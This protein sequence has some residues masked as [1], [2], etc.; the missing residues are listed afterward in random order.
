MTVSTSSIDLR[1]LVREIP[2]FPKPGILFRDLTP[3]MRDIDVWQEVIRRLSD[4]CEPLQPDLIVGIESRGFIVGMALSMAMGLGFVP[5][6]KPGKLPGLLHRVDYELEYGSDRLEIQRDAFVTITTSATTIDEGQVLTT[7]VNTTGIA[8]GTSL[9]Y[10]LSGKG[11]D[12]A[13]FASGRLT[14][15]ETVG[16]DGSF[17]L[18]HT[19]AND[20]SSEGPE[21]L[22]IRIFADSDHIH[23]L[24]ATATVTINDTSTSPACAGR[25]VLVVDDLLATGGTAAA[26]GELVTVAGGSLCGFA[27]V[28]E[29]AGLNGRQKLPA[30]VPVESLIIYP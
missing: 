15:Q 18:S 22:E 28:I 19:I 11:I 1:Q 3:L 4:Q 26:A 21:V 30:G 6:R 10:N 23:Q 9:H 13:D 25:R 16:S 27:F 8:A 29:L 2:D 20:E 7:T 17:R 24:G 14:G 12:A 5:I